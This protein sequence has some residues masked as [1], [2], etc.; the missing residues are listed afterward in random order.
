L[1]Y[2]G[3][4]FQS[5]FT[6]IALVILFLFSKTG[7]QKNL[8]T[9]LIFSYILLTVASGSRSGIINIFMYYFAGILILGRTMVFRRSHLLFI[10]GFLLPIAFL[11]YI[12]GSY[13]RHLRTDG[14]SAITTE[15]IEYVT[16]SVSNLEAY[17]QVKPFVGEAFA[18]AG[19]TDAGAEIYENQRFDE[20][21]NIVVIAKSIIDNS[22]P[23]DVFA[24]GR[25]LG[26][27]L[28]DVYLYRDAEGY[29]SD[30]VT[31]PAE[32]Y[33]IFGWA[34]L[35]VMAFIAF[36]FSIFYQALPKNIL[37]VFLRILLCVSFVNWWG[38]FG[39]DWFFIEFSRSAVLILLL[40]LFIFPSMRNKALHKNNFVRI[41]P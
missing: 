36:G 40:S 19:F 25:R 11:I 39:F 38:G 20:A 24:D 18:R 1:P 22:I 27:R 34:G 9:F 12:A 35:I 7:N 8:A 33:R 6:P 31:A 21:V 30:L 41:K 5:E 28:R 16:S 26:Y 17:E 4:I 13:Q 23:G 15:H 10:I 14:L 2:S 37:G 29:Q 3:L 32:L